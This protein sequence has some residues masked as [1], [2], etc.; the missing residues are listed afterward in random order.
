M[1]NVLGLLPHM[2]T[3]GEDIVKCIEGDCTQEE[4]DKTVDDVYA[5]AVSIP[6]VQGI[7]V[8]MQIASYVS[9]VSFPLVDGF[10]N[11]KTE[12]DTKKMKSARSKV[13]KTV[14][15]SDVANAQRTVKFFDE[16]TAKIAKKNK[17]KLPQPDTSWTENFFE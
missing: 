6:Q 4:W 8:I 11:G 15:K 3:I 14:S 17:I 12:T 2:M 16:V 10:I 7:L 13:A 5:M 1:I 9:K